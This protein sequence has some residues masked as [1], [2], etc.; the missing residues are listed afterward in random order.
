M[1][2]FFKALGYVI[3]YVLLSPFLWF[4]LTGLGYR[5][6]DSISQFL[7]MCLVC[8]SYLFVPGIQLFN[9]LF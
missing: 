1:K 3:A 5:I 9:V 2:R 7:G 6:A 4:F 8:L